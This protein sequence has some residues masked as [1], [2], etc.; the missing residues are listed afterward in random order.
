MRK[1]FLESIAILNLVGILLLVGCSV[2]PEKISSTNKEENNL[3]VIES[4]KLYAAIS[5]P[6]LAKE[7][8]YI[9]RAKVVDV[10][11]SFVER[12]ETQIGDPSDPNSFVN[13]NE[14][15]FTPITFEVLEWI[16]GESTKNKITYNQPGGK[17][18]DYIELPAGYTL[19]EGM[20]LILFLSD[21]GEKGTTWG[22]QGEFLVINDKVRVLEENKLYLDEGKI[23]TLS[24]EEINTS[25][26]RTCGLLKAGDECVDMD[27]FKEIIWKFMKE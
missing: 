14:D 3:P 9:V 12:H 11:E 19:K 13:V 8:Q 10:G 26:N 23:N 25:N 2:K 17:T 1:N 27:Y 16:K 5:L 20:E 22:G 6:E 18:S 4:T 24:Q 15:A 21:L 7:A